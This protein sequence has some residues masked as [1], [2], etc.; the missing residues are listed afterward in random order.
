MEQLTL[1]SGASGALNL[2]HLLLKTGGAGVRVQ[3]AGF[4]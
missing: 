3:T 2:L 4:L 1:L